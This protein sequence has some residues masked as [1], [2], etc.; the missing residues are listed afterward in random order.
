MRTTAVRSSDTDILEK[1]I[2][3]LDAALVEVQRELITSLVSYYQEGDFDRFAIVETYWK[4]TIEDGANQAV[5]KYVAEVDIPRESE[6]YLK[7]KQLTD[8]YCNSVL[9]NLSDLFSAVTGAKE[10]VDVDRT[11]VWR[12][13]DGIVGSAPALVLSSDSADGMNNGSMSK[14]ELSAWANKLFLTIAAAAYPSIFKDV[15]KIDSLGWLA[16]V[17]DFKSKRR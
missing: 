15:E 12:I 17:R 13:I 2:E 7:L 10:R 9:K 4:Q 16:K 3:K 8:T 14:M 11:I 1:R 5:A 6:S